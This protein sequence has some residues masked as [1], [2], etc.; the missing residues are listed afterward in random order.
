MPQ[1]EVLR[2]EREA[3]L[4][5]LK[6]RAL[7]RCHEAQ[8]AYAACVRGRVVSVAW[9]CRQEASHMSTCLAEHTSE[10]ALQQLIARWVAKGRPSLLVPPG[11]PRPEL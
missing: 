11:T 8:G 9:A 5:V 3:L 7:E 4:S 10:A 1:E 6:E 2:K